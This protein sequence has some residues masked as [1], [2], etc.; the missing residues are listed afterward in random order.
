MWLCE[1]EN[2]PRKHGRQHV[3]TKYIGTSVTLLCTQFNTTASDITIIP[4]KIAC[5]HTD[6]IYTDGGCSLSI[7]Y[8]ITMWLICLCRLATLNNKRTN[9]P[10]NEERNW[11]YFYW[12][13]SKKRN[14]QHLHRHKIYHVVNIQF[15]VGEWN[16]CGEKKNWINNG[17]MRERWLYQQAADCLIQHECTLNSCCCCYFIGD[18][19]P[20]SSS[21]YAFRICFVLCTEFVSNPI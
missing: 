13:T 10:T 16:M 20:I 6:N 21:L 12:V 19:F 4:L 18:F 3:R 17:R 15:S 8:F 7:S 1:Y 9:Q 2:V 5:I 14:Q 11:I